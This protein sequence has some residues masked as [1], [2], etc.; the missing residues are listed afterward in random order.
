MVALRVH[1]S[2][3]A[4]A[5]R[6]RRHPIKYS[7]GEAEHQLMCTPIRH[8][9]KRVEILFHPND[10]ISFEAAP[11]VVVYEPGGRDGGA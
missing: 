10:R 1:R 11:V 8:I 2:R 7:L 4:G 6:L 3:L 9:K 5:V